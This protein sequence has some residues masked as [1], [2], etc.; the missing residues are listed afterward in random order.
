M[1]RFMTAWDHKDIQGVLDAMSV[2]RRTHLYLSERTDNLVKWVNGNTGTWKHLSD[3]ADGAT[4][5]RTDG[6][7]GHPA[8]YYDEFRERR[9]AEVFANVVAVTGESELGTAL[10]KRFF[11]NIY[12]RSHVNNAPAE[13]R[14]SW[15]VA[16]YTWKDL[17]VLAPDWERVFGEALPLGPVVGPDQVPMVRECIEKRSKEPLIRYIKSLPPDL[18]Y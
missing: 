6:G 11:P 17:E 12:D 10:V 5:G 1:Y 7:W 13:L 15:P 14:G 8:E 18:M 9:T 3:L 16:D 2:G 4:V